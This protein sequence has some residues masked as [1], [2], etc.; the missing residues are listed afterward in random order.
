MVIALVARRLVWAWAACLALGRSSGPACAA[1]GTQPAALIFLHGSGDTGE[2]VRAWLSQLG[3]VAECERAGLSVETPSATPRPYKLAGGRVMSVW[4][5]RNG[6][7]PTAEEHLASV[8]ASCAE[9]E[10]IV[11]KLVVSGTPAE[12]IVIGGFSMGGASECLRM[13]LTHAITRMRAASGES[14]LHYR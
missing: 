12:R 1:H 4:Y 10:N 9:L 7:L 13:Q 3:F 5:D 8:E 14:A 11:S 6:L 2:G